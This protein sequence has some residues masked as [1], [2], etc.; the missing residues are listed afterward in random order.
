VRT[1]ARFSDRHGGYIYRRYQ[2]SGDDSLDESF[3]PVLWES[4]GQRTRWIE[5]YCETGRR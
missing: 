1:D 3:F 2:R 4:A 5:R